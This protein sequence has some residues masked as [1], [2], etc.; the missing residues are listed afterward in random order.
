MAAP[1]GSRVGPEW[2]EGIPWKCSLHS[3]KDAVGAAGSGAGSRRGEGAGM[4]LSPLR[5]ALQV[6]SEED[7]A[8]KKLWRGVKGKGF[9]F[10]WINLQ[11]CPVWMLPGCSQP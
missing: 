8:E 10:P 7:F 2:A 3:L 4:A 11:S 1:G 5:G 6:S 9:D